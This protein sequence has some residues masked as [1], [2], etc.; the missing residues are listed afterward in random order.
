MLLAQDQTL[1]TTELEYT[2][3][4]SNPKSPWLITTE[5][6]FLCMLHEQCSLY[7]DS[8]HHCHSRAQ[9]PGGSIATCASLVIT[10]G[11]GN[12]VNCELALK[13]SDWK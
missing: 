9:A 12:M 7:G 1:R 6:Y 5:V 8:A 2:V 4:T 3:V 13:I 11:K 10:E